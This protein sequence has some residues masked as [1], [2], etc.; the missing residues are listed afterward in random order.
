MTERILA[1]LHEGHSFGNRA[2][3][4]LMESGQL[5]VVVNG[6]VLGLAP[7]ERASDWAANAR[8]IAARTPAQAALFFCG[9]MMGLDMIRAPIEGIECAPDDPPPDPEDPAD[10]VGYPVRGP[11]LS[12]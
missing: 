8:N 9:L 4:V 12:P 3:I 5:A 10:Q 11:V 7:D 1:E 6:R 2:Q